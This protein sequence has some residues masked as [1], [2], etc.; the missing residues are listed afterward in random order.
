MPAYRFLFVTRKI[1]GLPSQDALDLPVA[2]AP[3]AGYEILPT[4]DAKA[5]VAYLLS[6]KNDYHL[7]D[8]KGPV[9]PP[10]PAQP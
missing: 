6:L 3:P 9:P 1:S 4:A 5:L 10:A 7:P 8:E 2:D